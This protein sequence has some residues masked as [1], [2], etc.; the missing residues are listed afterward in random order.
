M[1]LSK[2]D[3]WIEESNGRFLDLKILTLNHMGCIYRRDENF[4]AAFGCLNSAL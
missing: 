2:C 3:Q 1:L 4:E